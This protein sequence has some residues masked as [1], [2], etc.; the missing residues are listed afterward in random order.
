VINPTQVIDT[1]KLVCR[2]EVSATIM[3]GCVEVGGFVK[4]WFFSSRHVIFGPRNSSSLL[5][6][7]AIDSAQGVL[8]SGSDFYLY[9]GWVKIV[10][11]SLTGKLSATGVR[12]L[13]KIQSL[14]ESYTL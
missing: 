13:E 4:A 5:L 12:R 3:R 1:L 10:K 11:E 8:L 7:A 2:L 9:P 6:S 14:T